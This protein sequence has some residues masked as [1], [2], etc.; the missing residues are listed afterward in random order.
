MIAA[1]LVVRNTA[2]IATMNGGENG[3][4]SGDVSTGGPA[5]GAAL[6]ELGLVPAGALAVDGERIAWVGPERELERRVELRPGATTI[7]AAG[8]VVLPGFVDPHTH[9]VFAGSR[10]NEFDLR[11]QGV[12][13]LEIARR[14]GGILSSVRSF[15]GASDEELERNARRHLDSM[16]LLGTTTVEAKSGYGL[17]VADELRCFEIMQRLDRAHP[18]DLVPTFLGAHAVPPEYRGSTDDYVT[19]IVDEML[20]AVAEQGLA[21]FCDVFCEPGFFDLEQSRRVLTAARDRGM[22]LKVH[23]DEFEELGGAELAIELGAVS[24][25]HL[26]AMGEGAA[27]RMADS[28][29]MPVLLPGTSFFLGMQRFA[30]GR[31][32]ADLGLPIALATDLNPG[33]SMMSSMPLITTLACLGLGLRPAEALMAATRNAAHAAGEGGDR[34]WLG[35][36]ALADLQVLDLPSAIDLP[37]HVG[38]AHASWVV[39]RGRVVVHHGGLVT[40]AVSAR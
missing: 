4:G 3:A 36:G 26:M 13:Y 1:D 14:G 32:L 11:V 15:R 22:E 7:D 6:A 9:L 16:L 12:S 19:L 27:R 37:Y 8:G 34:G 39:K 35:A 18:I 24:A 17:N 25:D 20:P 29:T 2:E 23:A 30:R 21:R 28:P 31:W 5:R 38:P 33:S 40:T 10:A